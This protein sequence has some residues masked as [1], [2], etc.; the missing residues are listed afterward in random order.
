M[1]EIW[2]RKRLERGFGTEAS[3]VKRRIDEHPGLDGRH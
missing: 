2:S 1:E 3:H